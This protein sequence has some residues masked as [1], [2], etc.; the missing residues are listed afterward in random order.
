MTIAM[1]ELEQHSETFRRFNNQCQINTI[2]RSPNEYKAFS[3]DQ[4][5]E[6]RSHAEARECF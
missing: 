2:A 4:N 1:W 6:N 5:R 3:A